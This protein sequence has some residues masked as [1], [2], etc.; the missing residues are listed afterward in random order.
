MNAGLR[1]PADCLQKLYRPFVL[2][3]ILILAILAT[4]PPI[5]LFS[6][7]FYKIFLLISFFLPTQVGGATAFIATNNELNW[8]TCGNTARF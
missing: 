7:G 3:A 6:R 8:F 5:F 1:G 4:D 2:D